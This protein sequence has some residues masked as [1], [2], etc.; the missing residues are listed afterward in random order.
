MDDYSRLQVYTF[1]TMEMEQMLQAIELLVRQERPDVVLIDGIVDLI[2]NF[3]EVEESQQVIKELIKLASADYSGQDVAIVCVL[4]ENKLQ[5]DKNMRG[6]LGTM[7]SQ[8][9]GIVLECVK[10]DDVFTVRCSD[11]RHQPVPE[12]SFLYDREGQVVNADEVRAERLEAERELRRQLAEQRQ[13]EQRDEKFILLKKIVK[14]EGGCILRQKLAEKYAEKQGVKKDTAYYYLRH[15]VEKEL[16][17]FDGK[18]IRL[19]RPVENQL[20]FSDTED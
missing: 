10:R 12:W 7:L 19:E 11:S 13:Q 8:K 15:F 17:F 16:L 1:R 18:F 6:H 14:K 5:E 20:K 2:H 9:A 4:H 3:N